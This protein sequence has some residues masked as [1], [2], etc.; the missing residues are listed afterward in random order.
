MSRQIQFALLE[1]DARPSAASRI[2][3]RLREAAL[4]IQSSRTGC[5]KLSSNYEAGTSYKGG[6]TAEDHIIAARICHE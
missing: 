1:I 4:S 2:T 3:T 6:Q 5:L